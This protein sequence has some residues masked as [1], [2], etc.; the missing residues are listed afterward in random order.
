MIF[1]DLEDALQSTDNWVT[2][3]IECF[4]CATCS[5]NVGILLMWLRTKHSRSPANTDKDCS[6]CGQWMPICGCWDKQESKWLL[7]GRA[8]RN[9][10]TRIDSSAP[11]LSCFH[12][13]M[14]DLY[15]MEHQI[16]LVRG[17]KKYTGTK[18]FSEWVGGLLD[19]S[20]CNETVYYVLL[21][22]QIQSQ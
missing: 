4:C 14:A 1:Y 2:K 13:M 21:Q 12:N 20:Q 16:T 9:M 19:L 11:R 8:N 6:Q 15:L 22:K 10:G 17:W 18:W 5:L 3:R 7:V